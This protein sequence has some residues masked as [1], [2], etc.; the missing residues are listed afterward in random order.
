MYYLYLHELAFSIK[1]PQ[2]WQSRI[3][4]QFCLLG[5]KLTSEMMKKTKAKSEKVTPRL[6]GKAHAVPQEAAITRTKTN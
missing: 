6:Q 4:S 2:G 5:R 3:W 1:E